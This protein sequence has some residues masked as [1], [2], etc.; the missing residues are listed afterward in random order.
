ML[1]HRGEALKTTPKSRKPS[2]CSDA[3]ISY[4]D[5]PCGFGVR[6]AFPLVLVGIWSESQHFNKLPGCASHPPSAACCGLP[7]T[8]PALLALAPWGECA[9]MPGQPLGFMT[10][11]ISGPFRDRLPRDCRMCTSGMCHHAAAATVT[12]TVSPHSEPLGT[13]W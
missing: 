5:R 8:C 12:A 1:N 13:G 11:A 4:D 10:R 9:V 6:E 3:R 2:R 7:S